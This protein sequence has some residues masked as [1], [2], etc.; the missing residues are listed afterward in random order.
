MDRFRKGVKGFTCHHIGRLECETRCKK[1]S[2]EYQKLTWDALRKSINGLLNKVNVTNIKNVILELFSENLVRGKELL[3]VLLE[4]PTADSVEVA[5]GF[6]TECGSMLQDLS[7]KGLDAAFERFRGI[8]HEGEIDK[9]VQFLIEGLFAI[10]K[11]R[12]QG[13]PAVCP[14]LDLIEQEDQSTHEISL[15]EEIDTEITSDIFKPDPLFVENE[16][17]YEL[18][19]KSILGEECDE[20]VVSDTVSDDEEEEDYE[21]ESED[22]KERNLD[23]EEAGHKLMKLKLEP[24]QEMELCNM[25]LEC[26]IQEG[27]YRRYYGLL[28]QRLCMISGVYQ[29]NFEKCFVQHKDALPWHVLAYIRLTLEDTTSSSRIF[30]KSLFQELEQHLG[31]RKLNERLSDPSLQDSLASIFPKD[32]IKNMRFSI[33]FFTAI[34][35]GGITET[36]RK[37]LNTMKQQKHFS[38]FESEPD[39]KSIRRAASSDSDFDSSKLEVD[40]LKADRKAASKKRTRR[41]GGDERHTKQ[42]KREVISARDEKTPCMRTARLQLPP[43][44][45]PPVMEKA[46]DSGHE[47]EIMNKSSVTQSL[48]FIKFSPTNLKNQATLHQIIHKNTNN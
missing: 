3:A 8:L 14:E 42:S 48:S 32:E 44:R 21:E 5:V 30:I 20:E 29:E 33:N 36:L 13:Y 16:R 34:G 4:N 26:C 25:I 7:P 23:F 31:L 38:E 2:V 12:F 17:R 9:R 11:A 10:R 39:D 18:L 27:T 28:G 22:D 46:Y 15:R 45:K 37:Y 35:L 40:S 43:A 6:V 24:G 47:N 1:K 19:K 41:G